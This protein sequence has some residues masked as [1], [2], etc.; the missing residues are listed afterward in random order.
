[1]ENVGAKGI[2]LKVELLLA[3][4][5]DTRHMEEGFSTATCHFLMKIS[6]S[7]TIHPLVNRLLDCLC[8]YNHSD[9]IETCYHC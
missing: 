8:R 4:M 3:M 5:E 6:N 1:M 9:L 2:D 7:A